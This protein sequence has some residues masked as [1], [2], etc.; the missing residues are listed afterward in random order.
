MNRCVYETTPLSKEPTSDRSAK[1]LTA[2]QA[3]AV[4]QYSA[5]VPAWYSSGKK[6]ENKVFAF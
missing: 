4:L 5:G 6:E 1:M 2:T 3:K